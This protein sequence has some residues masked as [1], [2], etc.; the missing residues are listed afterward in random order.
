MDIARIIGH[1]HPPA[2]KDDSDEKRKGLDR[3]V[4]KVFE[5][6][7]HQ[8]PKHITGALQDQV[9]G[10]AA[11]GKREAQSSLRTAHDSRGQPH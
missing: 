6:L 9:H 11:Q 4:D 1:I 3:L 7:R 5:L 10:V 2:L 8:M